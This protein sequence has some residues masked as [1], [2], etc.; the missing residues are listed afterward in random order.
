MNYFFSFLECTRQIFF[1]EVCD[2]KLLPCL[3]KCLDDC[4]FTQEL[5]N[6]FF[7]LSM[8]RKKKRYEDPTT[9]FFSQ[10]SPR[11][12]KKSNFY[13]FFLF[14]LCSVLFATL[15][16]IIF[17]HFRVKIIFFLSTLKID[18]TFYI[19]VENIQGEIFLTKKDDFDH[20]EMLG[21]PENILKLPHMR[22]CIKRGRCL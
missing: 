5:K 1:L 22:C 13:L 16:A 21:N 10:A 6:F 17:Y 19:I 14:K 20:R 12:R 3:H 9:I 4:R 11:E 15:T 8:N 7:A 18:L 2:K